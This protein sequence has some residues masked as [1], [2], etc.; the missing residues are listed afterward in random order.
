MRLRLLMK[1]DSGDKTRVIWLAIFVICLFSVLVAQFFTIQVINGDYWSEKARR[2]HYFFVEEPFIRGTFYSNPSIKKGH[3]EKPYRFVADVQKFHLHAD[4]DSIPESVRGQLAESLASL[5]ELP[6]DG[7][8]EHLGKKSRDRLLAMWLGPD[9]KDAVLSWWKE[10]AKERGI[11]RN[12]LFFVSDYQRSYPFGKM[13]GQIL[14]TVQNRRDDKTK[15]AIPT[16]GLE[17]SLNS[18]LQGKLGKRLLMRSPRHSMEWGEIAMPPENGADVYLTINHYLQAVAEEELEK[19]VKKS[20]AK[21]GWAVMMD[22][23][24]GEILALAQYPFFY[25]PQ[26]RDYFNDPDLT[27][28]TRARALTDALEPGSILKPFAILTAF[29]AN[30]EL[31]KEIFDPEEKIACSDGTLPGRQKPMTDVRVHKYLNLPMAMQKSSNIY[32]A[33]VIDRVIS[34]LGE[35]WYRNV[36]ADV[37][38]FGTKTDLE[39]FGESSGVLPTPGKLHPNGKLEWSKPTPYSLAIG[40]N[41]QLTSIQILRAWSLLANGGKMVRPTLVRKIVKDGRTLLDNTTDKRLQSFP[42]VIDPSTAAKVV[43]ALRF[44]TMP[45]GTGIKANIAG[46]TEIGKSGTSR[47]IENGSYTSKKHVASFVGF[48]PGDQ[49]RIHFAGHN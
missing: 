49:S 7:I 15:Q 8:R 45:G 48:V 38:G 29:M 37:F 44:D 12:A 6:I 23:H 1:A 2:Q 22:P 42:Q 10:F 9:K 4:P 47:K 31:G 46:F 40:H 19:G 11:V 32:M 33:K 24:T 36:L 39:L 28:D 35:R 16:G 26:Y 20:G 14:H 21:G 30:N 27:P 43:D 41:L 34:S 25:P 17:L 13:L 5:L 18:Y 3:P